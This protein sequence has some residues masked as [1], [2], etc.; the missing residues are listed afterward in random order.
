MDDARSAEIIQLMQGDWEYQE[1]GQYGL[2]YKLSVSDD[3]VFVTVTL[4]GDPAKN[5]GDFIVCN[6]V[7]LIHYDQGTQGHICIP[8][9]YENGEL[10]LYPINDLTDEATLD[11]AMQFITDDNIANGPWFTKVG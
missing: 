1:D 7:I 3:Y 6:D 9:T 11:P 2:N 10:K 4:L 5:Q 8:Y